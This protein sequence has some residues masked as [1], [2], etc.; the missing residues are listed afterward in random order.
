MSLRI[1][2]PIAVLIVASVGLAVSQD[3]KRRAGPAL[4]KSSDRPSAVGRT[5]RPPQAA[6]V[7][8][9]LADRFEILRLTTPRTA[10]DKVDLGRATGAGPSSGIEYDHARRIAT[11]G[12][13]AVW[14]APSGGGLCFLDRDSSRG[15]GGPGSSC[16]AGPETALRGE[17][18]MTVGDA[19]QGGADLVALVPDGVASA[20]V[21][22]SDG[23]SSEIPIRRNALALHV[24]KDT[25]GYTY[26]YGGRTVTVAA[27]TFGD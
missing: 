1:F 5:P 4:A 11:L 17:A 23:T 27:R 20:T 2:T 19:T 25:A 14:I 16:F 18:W 24:L 7:S 15:D 9:A 8:Q 10:A 13:H 6:P 21:M 3:S 22:F 12:M 26:E